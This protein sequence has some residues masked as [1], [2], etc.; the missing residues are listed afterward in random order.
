MGKDKNTKGSGKLRAP[1][2]QILQRSNKNAPTR[3]TAFLQSE[4]EAIQKGSVTY[5]DSRYR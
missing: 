2:S 3:A 4:K 5:K 1:D